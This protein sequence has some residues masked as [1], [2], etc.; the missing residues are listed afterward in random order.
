MTAGT[1]QEG[2]S[3]LQLSGHYANLILI[4]IIKLGQTDRVTYTGYALG[5]THA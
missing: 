3:N 2:G 4:P 1:I 5:Q